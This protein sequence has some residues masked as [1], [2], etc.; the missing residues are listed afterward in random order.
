MSNYGLNEQ[1]TRETSGIAIRH[2][3][4]DT[5]K[6]LGLIFAIVSAAFALQPPKFGTDSHPYWLT[7]HGLSY[8]SGPMTKDAYLYSPAFADVI[9]PLTYLPWPVF[10][11]FWSALLGVVLA[12]LLAPLRWWA[13]PL[14]IAGLPEIIHGNVFILLAVVAAFGL[15]RR[16]LWALAALTKI[17]LCVGPVWFAVRREWRELGISL[18]VISAI[19]LLSWAVE[20]HLWVEWITFLASEAGRSSQTLGLEILPSLV[21]RLPVALLLVAWG[22]HS[23]KRWVIPVGMVLASPVLW[24]GTFTM[25]AALPRLHDRHDSSEDR[26]QPAAATIGISGSQ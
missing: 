3:A 8:A 26:E 7:G 24:L 11:V 5:A 19:A 12:W 2:L 14:W 23:D 21:Y 10:A 16:G 22:A 15:Q 4:L 6:V 9:R 25:L 13:L 17:T 18:G 1:S 20:P